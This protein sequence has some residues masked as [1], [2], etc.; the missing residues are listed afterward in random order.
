MLQF[1]NSESLKN[2]RL[3]QKFEDLKMR[4]FEDKY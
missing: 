3:W 2:S 1:T 4:G